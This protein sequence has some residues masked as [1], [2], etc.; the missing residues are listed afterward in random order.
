M[1]LGLP[2]HLS[3]AANS[4]AIATAARWAALACLG[5]A[6]VNVAVSEVGKPNP[7]SWLT[8]LILVPMIGLM[9]L[10]SRRRTV[11]LT[12]AYLLVGAVCTYFYAVTLLQE[13]PGYRDTNLFVLALPV[14]AMTLVGG[15]GTGALIGILWATAGFALAEAAVILAAVATGREFR[16]DAISLGAYLLLVGVLSFDGLTRGAR[17]RPQS[18]LHRSVR[19]SRLIEL[20]R[21]LIAD[22]T[23]ELHDTV[24]SDLL[25]VANAE[26]GPI[27]PRLSAMLEADLR[28]IGRDPDV[29]A[30]VS[31]SSSMRG[32]SENPSVASVTGG[33]PGDRAG[34]GAPVAGAGNAW[35]DSELHQAIELARDEG[36][37][38]D[39]SGDRNA[40]CLL[41]PERR[42]AVGLAA[43]QCLVNVLR[44]SGSA[45]AEVTISA[46]EGAVSVMV[47]DGGRGFAPTST[48]ADRL[49]LRQSVHDRIERV[50][51]TVTVY[52]SQD[53]GTTVMMVVPLGTD[54]RDG[55][56]DEEA[57]A[58]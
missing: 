47:V 13:N 10:L 12:V 51:G 44:H 50:G 39:L 57:I 6:L 58:S 46:S 3:R 26:P 18:A 42:R 56:G 45:T 49:G 20:R 15:T 1:S 4:R 48:A 33:E 11:V 34:D 7:V 55:H 52:S 35:F 22:S 27:R 53:I 5:A 14:V 54:G 41:N 30:D 2:S 32:T 37:A 21:L 24:L 29:E 43:R 16:T 8:V 23:A 17:S 31:G 9:V 40:L 38:V 25:A 28:T 36:L 19:E